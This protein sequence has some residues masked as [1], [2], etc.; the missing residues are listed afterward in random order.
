M[1]QVLTTPFNAVVADYYLYVNVATPSSVVLP[2]SVPGKIFIVKDVSGNASVNN[3]TITT[4]STIDSALS[5]VIDL[6]YGSMTFIF[7]GSEWN[8]V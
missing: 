7:N 2:V 4:S 3:I 6:D 8:I 5:A 1:T